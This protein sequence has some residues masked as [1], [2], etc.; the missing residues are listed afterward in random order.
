LKKRGLR[1]DL[2]AVDHFLKGGSGGGVSF[3][4]DQ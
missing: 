2:L 3:S 1:G 4:G